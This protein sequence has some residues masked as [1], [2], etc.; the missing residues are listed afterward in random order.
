MGTRNEQASYRASSCHYSCQSICQSACQRFCQ[1]FRTL[2]YDVREACS[3]LVVDLDR[4]GMFQETIETNTGVPRT[5]LRDWVKKMVADGVLTPGVVKLLEQ[6]SPRVEHGRASGNGG[7]QTN[8]GKSRDTGQQ[9]PQRECEKDE[10][11]FAQEVCSDEGEYQEN[12]ERRV[13]NVPS[14]HFS[15]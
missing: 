15:S 3:R 8:I 10:P 12:D 9:E 14:I 1:R 2:T 4:S 6:I 11:I 5:T 7:S 13:A